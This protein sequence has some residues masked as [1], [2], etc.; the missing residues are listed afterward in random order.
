MMQS[1]L[2]TNNP[3]AIGHTDSGLLAYLARSGIFINGGKV[4]ETTLFIAFN[5][6]HAARLESVIRCFWKLS[7]CGPPA[8]VYLDVNRRYAKGSQELTKAHIMVIHKTGGITNVF[9]AN[10]G[11][12]LD[13]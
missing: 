1:G 12:A 6:A 13:G 11:T 10:I 5:Q 9:A 8:L 3:M 2:E 4:P 7:Q